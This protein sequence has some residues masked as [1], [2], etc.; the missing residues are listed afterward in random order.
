M[1]ESLV[2]LCSSADLVEGG[3][4]PG[5]G[6]QAGQRERGSGLQQDATG[7]GHRGSPGVEAMTGL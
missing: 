3:L 7:Q 5:T 6:R 2:P 4:G 1:S